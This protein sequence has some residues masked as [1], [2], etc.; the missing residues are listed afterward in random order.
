LEIL[1]PDEIYA[2]NAEGM[3]AVEVAVMPD[4]GDGLGVLLEGGMRDDVW[5]NTPTPSCTSKR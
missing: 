4:N 2:R 3:T 1:L 5:G